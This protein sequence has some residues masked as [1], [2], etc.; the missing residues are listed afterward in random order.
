MILPLWLYSFG[1]PTSLL[2]LS[3]VG[4]FL[5]L[6]RALVYIASS[7]TQIIGNTGVNECETQH[8]AIGAV[9]V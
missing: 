5:L 2:P 1:P 6:R 4:E 9:L 8:I 7:W 3:F